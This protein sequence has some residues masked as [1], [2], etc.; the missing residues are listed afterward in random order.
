MFGYLLDLLYLLDWGRIRRAAI[1]VAVATL[2]FAVLV[3]ALTRPTIIHLDSVLL[4]GG[5]LGGW[6]WREW[7]H[8][9]EI[10]SI[11][12]S[13][14]G[15]FSSMGMLIGL[16]RFPETGNILDLILLSYPLEHW[17]GWPMNHNLKVLLI[18]IGNG[19]CGY[20][21]AR[22]FTDLMDH[23]VGGRDRRYFESIGDSRHQQVGFETGHLVVVVV[24]PH[25]FAES[26]THRHHSGCDCRGCL[27]RFD[28][29][30]LLV[31]WNVCWNDDP[32]SR[33]V[34]VVA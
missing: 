33:G 12:G 18:L 20:A 25:I 24:V 10:E 19:I 32:D 11:A 6:R 4:G 16:G 21:L 30:I 23:C 26:P 15:L 14:M 13:D 31:L 3:T 5:E 8:F 29:R 7:W 27:V 28:Q 17:F 22:T 34:L 9:K 2:S 1:E